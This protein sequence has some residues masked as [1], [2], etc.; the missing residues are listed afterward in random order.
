MDQPPNITN[1]DYWF[2]VV[3]F[4]QQNWAV[5]EITEAGCT[6]FFFGDTANIFDQIYFGSI[7]DAEAAL[8]RNDF[9]R[10]AGDKE[11]QKFI[12][13]PQPPF[14]LLPHPD[15]PIYSSGMYWR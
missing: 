2:K 5:T 3:D 12:A 8:E 10:Y 15:G 14:S 13:R 7:V 9:S 4:L 1:T 6:V 11:V